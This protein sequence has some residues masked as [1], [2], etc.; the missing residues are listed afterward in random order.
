M[1]VVRFRLFWVPWICAGVLML[2]TAEPAA[3]QQPDEG[4][5]EVQRISLEEALRLFMRNNPQLQAA[6]ATV[7]EAQGRLTQVRAYPN[8]TVEVTHEPLFGG[9][10]RFSETY[11]NLA[12]SLQWPGK[13]R[14]R[15]EAAERHAEAVRA[16]ARAD[17]LRYAFD[18]VALFVEAAAEE[19]RLAAIQ[20]VTNLFEEVQAIG[21][22]RFQE[23]DL[24]GYALHRMR[25]EQ[26]RYENDILRTRLDLQED[27]RQL[28]ALLYPEDD[29]RAVA[30]DM[31]V[32]SLPEVPALDDLMEVALN[33]RPAVRA[34]EAEVA[35]ARAQLESARTARIPDVTVT[36]GYKRQSDGLQGLFLGTSVPIPLFDRGE[37][38]IQIAEADLQGA[39]ARLR[40]RRRQIRTEVQSAYDEYEAFAER[41]AE[42]R[43]QYEGETAQTVLGQADNLM[44]VARVSYEEGNMSLVELLDAATAYREAQVT[45]A[46]LRGDHLMSYF[47]LRRATG[48]LSPSNDMPNAET[49]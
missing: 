43:Q 42:V 36:G 15:I 23:G 22:R 25:I 39:Q 16:G 46:R 41:L 7:R 9:E 13:R 19:R 34:A 31:N 24:S 5:E 37:G 28:A 45:L 18:V 35:A 27:W 6:S 20:E 49:Q 12:Q 29:A 21:A 2:W 3:S 32:V 1:R 8:P 47:K 48:Q 11:V 30:P 17:S 33:R 44:Q 40:L 26:T 4:T 10:E 38:A 14:A